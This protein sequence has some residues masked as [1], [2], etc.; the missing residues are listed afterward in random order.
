MVNI[1]LVVTSLFVHSYSLFKAVFIQ[2]NNTV[3]DNNNVIDLYAGIGNTMP[4]CHFT[5]IK[6]PYE[7]IIMSTY[8]VT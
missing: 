3:F 1:R 5:T 8:I 6:R 4:I 2:W 7:T